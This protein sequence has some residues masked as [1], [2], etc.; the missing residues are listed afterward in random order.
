MSRAGAPML[1]LRGG[2]ILDPSQ[3]LDETGDVLLSN[4]FVRP[5]LPIPMGR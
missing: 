4:G 2:R 3:Q 1:L 5:E